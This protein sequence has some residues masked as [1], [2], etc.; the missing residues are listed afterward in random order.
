MKKQMLLK[1]SEWQE[2][3]LGK[4][5]AWWVKLIGML[6]NLFLAALVVA[7][8]H[9]AGTGARR[10]IARLARLNSGKESVSSLFGTVAYFIVLILGIAIALSLLD[11]KQALS[12]LLAGAGIVGIVLGFAFQ[13]L[14]SNLISGVFI[15][16]RRPFEKGHVVETNGFMGIIEEIQIRTTVIRTFQGL[17]LMI[18]NRDIIQK[19]LTNYSLALDR[20]VEVTFMISPA[21]DLQKAVACASKAL[22]DI[23]YRHKEKPPEVYL[24]GISEN[25]VRI[26]CWLWIYNHL[27]PGFMVAQHDV[28]RS[29]TEAFTK[30]NI[31]L[32]LPNTFSRA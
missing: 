14:S 4:L 6:P 21:N 7:A 20:R 32:L 31:D 8:A 17:H 5:Y 30:N 16:L 19:P 28:I 2:I 1:W 13:D 3:L 11:L 23:S 25:A 24:S 12:S 22:S 15:A 29:V 27:P 18:P 9:F 10:V 26:A